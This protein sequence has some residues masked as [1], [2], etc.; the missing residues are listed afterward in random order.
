MKRFIGAFFIMA[1]L[2]TS[3]EGRNPRRPKD[4]TT[5]TITIE[6]SNPSIAKTWI[7]PKIKR[8]VRELKTHVLHNPFLRLKP[9]KGFDHKIFKKHYLPQRTRI[10][11]RNDNGSIRTCELD[12]LANGL[13]EELKAGQKKFTHFKVLKD[14]D[15][16][17]KS[18]SGL[19][20]LKFKDYPFVLKLSLEHPHTMAKPYE[21]SFEAACIFFIGGNVRHLSNFTRIPNLEY[22][23]KV[24]SYNPYYIENLSF[25]RKWFWQPKNNYDL[26]ITWE[27]SPYH[28]EEIITMPSIYGIIS[29]YIETEDWP[30][31]DLANISMRVAGDVGFAL[32]PHTGNF[33][34]EKG[35]NKYSLIDTEDFRIM[36]GLDHT[37][38]SKNYIGWLMEMTGRGVQIYGGRTKQDRIR[39]S[40]AD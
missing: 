17:Y 22:I 23:K 31:K 24:L 36:G 26:K 28:D 25:P 8:K 6:A 35:K 32:D 12:T 37:L 19:L 40:Y 15:F 38:K 27:K 2:Y 16:S 13:V 9:L 34:R 39:H 10:N 3:L 4:K 1:I 14:R 21:K 7:S 11:Y 33:V 20:V 5:P 29:D 30:S 18:L